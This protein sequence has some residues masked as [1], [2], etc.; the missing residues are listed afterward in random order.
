MKHDGGS[1][2]VWPCFAPSGPGW[3]VIIDGVMN[4]AL[5]Q[6]FI[7]QNVGVF[8]W[9]LNLKKKVGHAARQEPTHKWLDR[10]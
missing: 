3:F 7:N 10:K 8:V 1:V 4:F 5:Y 9:E 2:T 6:G